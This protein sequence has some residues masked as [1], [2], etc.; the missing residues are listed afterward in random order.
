MCE[1]EAVSCCPRPP[2]IPF[3]FSLFGWS[4]TWSFC[5]F[6]GQAKRHC[7]VAADGIFVFSF[8]SSAM[9]ESSSEDARCI[10]DILSA[11]CY[12]TAVMWVLCSDCC[13]CWCLLA[14][15]DAVIVSHI[16]M[17]VHT[18]VLLFFRRMPVLCGTRRTFPDGIIHTL[19]MREAPRCKKFSP[20]FLASLLRYS[21]ISL[22][23][24]KHPTPTHTR[25]RTCG[26]RCVPGI[27]SQPQ[28]HVHTR[29]HLY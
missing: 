27:Y 14:F 1:V 29:I 23:F 13:C 22:L 7:I 18:Y 21:S 25:R 28:T 12:H 3:F 15:P 26:I 17:Y 19:I 20:T 10:Y 9:H 16:R 8:L 24:W 5:A 4:E 11:H 2:Y 6:R